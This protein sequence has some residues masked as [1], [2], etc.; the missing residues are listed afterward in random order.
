MN[1]NDNKLLGAEEPFVS[2]CIFVQIRTLMG[3]VS[4]PELVQYDNARPL[5]FNRRVK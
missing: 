1:G 5:Q 4:L 2:V 3:D